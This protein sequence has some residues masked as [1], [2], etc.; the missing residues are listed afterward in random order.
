MKQ[1]QYF[2]H[3]YIFIRQLTDKNEEGSEISYKKIDN[4]FDEIFK[5][6]SNEIIRKS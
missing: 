3:L 5:R 6:L 4:T 1:M 2:I